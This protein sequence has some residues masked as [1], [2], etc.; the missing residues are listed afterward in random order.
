MCI[1]FLGLLK[2]IPQ[3][4]GGLKQ[5]KF[6]LLQFWKQEVKSQDINRVKEKE[7]IFPCCW[8]L[9]AILFSLAYSGE[10]SMTACFHMA[11]FP[12]CFHIIF[13]VCLFVSLLFL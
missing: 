3:I 2:K 12:V 5:Q 7:K 8:W 13:L 9:P 6:V 10:T 11:F 4:G 1:S